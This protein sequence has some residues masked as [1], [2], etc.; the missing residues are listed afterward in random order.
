MVDVSFDEP[1]LHGCFE[2]PERTTRLMLQ[3]ADAVTEPTTR[4]AIDLLIG[5][6]TS[7]PP[8]DTAAGENLS[9]QQS[10]SS[11]VWQV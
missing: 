2:A 11:E 6:A 1:D 4:F 5:T 3:F 8:S 10:E 9:S 7:S